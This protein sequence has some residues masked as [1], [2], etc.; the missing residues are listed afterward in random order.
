MASLADIRAR[1]QAQDK[2][3]SGSFGDKAVF[4]QWNIQEG[5]TARLR[6][7]PDGNESNPYFWVER[8][9]IK[10]PFRGI[11]GQPESKQTPIVQVPC[12]EMWNE[13]CPVLTQVRPWFKDKSLEELGRKYWKKRSYVFQGFVRDNPL[14]KGDELPENPIRRFIVSPS[15]F[16]LI[17]AALL[18]P[19]I[20]ELPTHY[21]KGL[22]FF[23]TKTTKGGFADYSTSRWSRNESALTDAERAAIAQ[24]GLVNLVTF[25]LI[26]QVRLNLKLLKICSRRA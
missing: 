14:E 26:S 6:F 25:Y 23:V 1:L 20:Q 15:I 9:M 5:Q 21:D 17:K 18:D 11:K 22:D 3:S 13:T 24:Y 10:M 2:K 16:T 12:M 7:L 19:E 8:A 4:P